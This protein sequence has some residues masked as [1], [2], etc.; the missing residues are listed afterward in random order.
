L[1]FP[2]KSSL[3]SPFFPPLCFLVLPLYL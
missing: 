3:S 2:Q 1:F